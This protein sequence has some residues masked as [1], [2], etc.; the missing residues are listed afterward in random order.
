MSGV[1]P[2]RRE[3]YGV[4]RRDFVKSSGLAL[5]YWALWGQSEAFA[6]ESRQTPEYLVLRN[7]DQM[8]VTFRFLN[9]FEK[10]EKLWPRGGNTACIVLMFG[11]QNLA[12]EI[13]QQ[14]KEDS[15]GELMPLGPEAQA[16]APV[17]TFLSGPSWLVFK[18]DEARGALPINPQVWLERIADSASSPLLVPEEVLQTP[19]PTQKKPVVP[20]PPRENR[21]SIEL[22][23]RLFLAPSVPTA[24]LPSHQRGFGEPERFNVSWHV[25]LRSLV[26][27]P[28]AAIPKDVPPGGLP[29]ELQPPKRL[30]LK[31]K[32]FYSP[33]HLRSGEP[34]FSL[35]FPKDRPLSLHAV[36][37]HLLVEQIMG[38]NGVID[39][40]RLE[41]S[42]RGGNASYYYA[43]QED[44]AEIEQQQMADVF[45]PDAKPDA[46]KTASLTGSAP[47]SGLKLYAWKHRIVIGRDVYFAEAFFLWAFPFQH[48][49]IYVEVTERKFV[50]RESKDGTISP[51]GAYELK[52][53]FVIRLQDLRRH[54]GSQSALGR[55]NAFKQVRLITP[56]SP[57]L[58]PWLGGRFAFIDDATNKE[59]IYFFPKDLDGNPVHWELEAEDESQ[60]KQ[61]TSEAQLFLASHLLVGRWAYSHP[62]MPEENRRI[63]FPSA[64]TAYAP[65]EP[66]VRVPLPG[67]LLNLQLSPDR[68]LRQLAAFAGR[69]MLD[70]L[71][72]KPPA[73]VAEAAAALTL[74][75]STIKNAGAW[76]DEAKNDLLVQWSAWEKRLPPLSKDTDVAAWNSMLLQLLDALTDPDFLQWRVDEGLRPLA[77]FVGKRV[78]E[79]AAVL[80]SNIATIQDAIDAAKKKAADSQAASWTQA[81]LEQ[82]NQELA[83]VW[84]RIQSQG[85]QVRHL[86]EEVAAQLGKMR[87]LT[88][89][90][91]TQAVYFTSELLGRELK[92]ARELLKSLPVADEFLKSFQT[93]DEL[94]T[95]IGT[96]L[97]ANVPDAE[98]RVVDRMQKLAE[99]AWLAVLAGID[100]L[101]GMRVNLTDAVQRLMVDDRTKLQKVLTNLTAIKSTDLATEVTIRTFVNQSLGKDATIADDE[102]NTLVNAIRDARDLLFARLTRLLNELDTA[103]NEA[104]EVGT[105]ALQAVIDRAEVVI[106]ALKGVAGEVPAKAVEYVGDYVVG[107]FDQAKNGTYAA[108]AEAIDEGKKLAEDVKN[109]L[110]T[111]ALAVAGLSREI[112]VIAG[113][114][115]DDVNQFAR[116][117]RDLNLNDA[118]PDAKLFGCLDLRDL[119]QP[120]LRGKLPDWKTVELPD[121]IE[122]TFAWLAPLKKL[123]LAIVTFKPSDTHQCHL[124]LHVRTTILLR[125]KPEGQVEIIGWVGAWN[126]N[127]GAVGKDGSQQDGRERLTAPD[128]SFALNLLELIEVGFS[129]LD[130]QANYRTSEGL[131]MPDVRPTIGEIRFQG[132]LK[133]VEKIEQ[134]LGDLFGGGF[135]IHITGTHIQVELGIGLPPISFGVF[136]LRNITF[137]AGLGL[138]LG[139]NPLRF[140]FALSSFEKPF[141]LSIMGFGGRGF[142]SIGFDTSG[143]RLLKGAFEFGGALSFDVAVASGGLYVMAGIYYEAHPGSMVLTGYLRAGGSLD[144][145]GLIHASVE[146]YL[147]FTYR[148]QDGQSELYGFCSITVSIE[149]CFWSIDVSVEMEKSIAGSTNSSRRRLARTL[150]AVPP[151]ERAAQ[152]AGATFEPGEEARPFISPVGGRF[153]SYE[154][155][156]SRYWSRFA[157]KEDAA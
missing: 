52:R 48:P 126:A 71:R 105:R 135:K 92:A 14:P 101:A 29:P 49:M 43:T 42:G 107:A 110:A 41:L 141:E 37:R 55:Q 97:A 54:L 80:E 63:P 75:R 56:Q 134:L 114:A 98:A 145:L 26:P 122:R 151:K 87:D 119:L 140:D 154:D 40:E 93:L 133:F 109:G 58:S 77:E 84:T 9:F 66:V 123:D 38:G 51:P 115:K 74:L 53:S 33:D 132:P 81:Q 1:P 130:L 6:T 61:R 102:T 103:Q 124:W 76:G 32:P 152:L 10:D 69:R 100:L 136:S 149:L 78:L 70:Q 30:V 60:Q 116:Q 73:G 137:W 113:Q 25:A 27:L 86:A 90:L 23:F 143:D 144:V 35:F 108:L 22:P 118:I 157:L 82:M 50:S 4:T 57:N 72:Q 99:A 13:F 28:P 8:A 7:A 112:G 5:G 46:K 148:E 146:F 121:R 117:V 2:D 111:P 19:D 138:P 3:L 65:E 85:A 128:E 44:I 45:D 104:E 131:K 15:N 127:E 150:Y 129:Q 11:P 20:I 36:T 47:K 24:A 31:A 68:D 120:L 156:E 16:V 155:F 89:T 62:L 95:W 67:G 94:K 91:E 147:G 21:T 106:P 139:E 34:D 88:T 79:T 125:P 96:T 39:V 83:V 142:L 17:H 18:Y 12:E 153:N 59:G 64:K